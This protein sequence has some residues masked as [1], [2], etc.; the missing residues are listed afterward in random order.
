[1]DWAVLLSRK[2]R[3]P[4]FCRPNTGYL[5]HTS[6]LLG[7]HRGFRGRGGVSGLSKDYFSYHRRPSGNGNRGINMPELV[8]VI[9]L[10]SQ[11]G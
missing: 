4:L 2:L 11:I 3:Y 10:S 1:M 9:L 7:K 5:R 6:H 8:S